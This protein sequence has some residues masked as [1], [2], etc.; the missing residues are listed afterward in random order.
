M[1]FEN[2]IK[3]FPQETLFYTSSKTVK[4]FFSAKTCKNCNLKFLV[5][6]RN[7]G[8][9]SK[10][11]SKLEILVKNGNFGKNSKF[12]SKLVI[13]TRKFEILGKALNFN[14]KFYI[15]FC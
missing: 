3:E 7:F 1:Y 6:T 4:I 5:K 11:W 8:Q 10:C 2:V 15:T 12:W 14:D 9:N 13:L